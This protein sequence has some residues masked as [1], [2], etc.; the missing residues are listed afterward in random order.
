MNSNQQFRDV[1][2]R[3]HHY[4]NDHSKTFICPNVEVVTQ[5]LNEHDYLMYR[6]VNCNGSAAYPLKC[7]YLTARPIAAL[8][9]YVQARDVG[10]QVGTLF[11]SVEKSSFFQVNYE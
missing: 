1:V 7:V 4:F 2:D 3:A 8:V 9:N 10:N 6:G 11:L 5:I